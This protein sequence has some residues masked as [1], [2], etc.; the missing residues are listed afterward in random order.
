VLVYY[1]IAHLAALR[2][3]PAQRWLPRWVQGL[4]IAGCLLLALTLPA[5]GVL[6]AA[7]WLAL[8]LLAR[9]LRRPRPAP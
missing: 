6:A 7:A 8:G 4:G 1:A 2:Q 9:A 5:P 3:P